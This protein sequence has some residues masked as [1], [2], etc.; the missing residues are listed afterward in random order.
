M[1]TRRYNGSKGSTLIVCAG[2]DLIKR[3]CPGFCIL[4]LVWFVS[5]KGSPN[6]QGKR[7]EQTM[8]K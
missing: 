3:Y 1:V 6:A 7:P 5:E 2:A 4:N 8:L